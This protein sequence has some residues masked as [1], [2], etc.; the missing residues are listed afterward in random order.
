[1][2]LGQLSTRTGHTHSEV[3]SMICPGSFCLFVCSILLSW[4]IRYDEFYLHVASTF[5]CNPVF[6]PEMGLYLVLLQSL[7]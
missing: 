6:C 2:E 4:A 5:F 3:F 7:R 1:M